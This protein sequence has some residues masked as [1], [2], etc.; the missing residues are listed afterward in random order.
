MSE[1]Y[2]N[3][4]TCVNCSYLPKTELAQYLSGRPRIPGWTLF[5]EGL[6]DNPADMSRAASACNVAYGNYDGYSCG[7]LGRE[8][9][10][11]RFPTAFINPVSPEGYGS[12]SLF[13]IP[14]DNVPRNG[15]QYIR[16]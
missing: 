6:S 4:N 9:Y 12:D 11:L 1:S 7:Y 2:G 3:Y 5:S 14:T 13:W 15:Y 16:R 8:P 10:G